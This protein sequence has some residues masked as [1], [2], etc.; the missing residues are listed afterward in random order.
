MFDYKEIDLFG[1]DDSVF[2]VLK[3]GLVIAAG[4]VREYD[5]ESIF[6]NW[7]IIYFDDPN[8]NNVSKWKRL[9]WLNKGKWWVP[10][11]EDN[12]EFTNFVETWLENWIGEVEE[13]IFDVNC[14]VLDD[15]HVVVNSNNPILTKILQEHNMEPIFCP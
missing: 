12:N 8:W 3:P 7:E 6:P 11:E 2:S 5:I 1:H 14:L 10:G 4:W 9:K 15:K 13:T